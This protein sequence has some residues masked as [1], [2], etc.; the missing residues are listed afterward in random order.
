ME[1]RIVLEE[2]LAQAASDW[3]AGRMN[4]PDADDAEFIPL[5]EDLGPPA[6]AAP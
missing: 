2:A 4:L 1:L 3:K 6:A 5:P